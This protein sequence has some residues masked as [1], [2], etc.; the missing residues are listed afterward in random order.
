MLRGG[1]D[2]DDIRH[3]SFVWHIPPP[4]HLQMTACNLPV[5]AF[6][7]PSFHTPTLQ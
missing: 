3:A 1:K 6:H 4:L 5:D 7:N 2:I